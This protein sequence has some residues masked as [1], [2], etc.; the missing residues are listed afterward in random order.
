MTM[1]LIYILSSLAGGVLVGMAGLTAAM[2]LTPI[3][4]SVCGWN[5]YDAVTM[6]LVANVPSAIIT[7]YTYYKNGNIDMKRGGSM[8]LSAFAGAVVGSWLGYL[9][10]K[11]SENGVSY[12]VIIMNLFLALQYLKPA[13]SKAQKETLTEQEQVKAKRKMVTA[14]ILGFLIGVECGFMGSAGGALMLMVLTLVLGMDAKM[15][16][17]TSSLVMTLVALTGAVSHLMMGAKLEIVPAI[18]MTISCTFGAVVSS[19]FANKV[20]D[21]TMNRAA[22]IVLILV[23]VASLLL[24]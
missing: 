8:A 13:K 16:V 2:V 20:S 17:G 24:G 5:G 18:V 15:A 7:S 3:L 21:T 11:V 14:L 23:S 6:S 22:A 10:S 9:F 4:G 1:Y 19:K 12:A